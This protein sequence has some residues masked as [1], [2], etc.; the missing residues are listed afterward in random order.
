MIAVRSHSATNASK[1]AAVGK[2][3]HLDVLEAERGRP[4]PQAQQRHQ[5]HLRQHILP[6]RAHHLKHPR[7]VLRQRLKGLRTGTS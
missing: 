4:R 1:A 3:A 2:A 7:A 5:P 6:G